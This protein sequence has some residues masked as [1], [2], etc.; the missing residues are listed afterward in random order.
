MRGIYYT[1]NTDTVVSAYANSPN[2]HLR[3]MLGALISQLNM[4]AP[5]LAIFIA[6]PAQSPIAAVL[7]TAPWNSVRLLTVSARSCAQL[8]V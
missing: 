8:T 3:K 6:A 1:R 4:I 7:P 5:A 2:E